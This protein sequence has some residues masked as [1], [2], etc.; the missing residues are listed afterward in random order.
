MKR[1][2]SSLAFEAS[3]PSSPAVKP[4]AVPDSRMEQ[5]DEIQDSPECDPV[6]RSLKE[7][8]ESQF[9]GLSAESVDKITNVEKG[10]SQESSLSERISEPGDK[11][12]DASCDMDTGVDRCLQ[13]DQGQGPGEH[14]DVA[15]DSDCD[16]TDDDQ[17]PKWRRKRI[18]FISSGL[19]PEK[20]VCIY[21]VDFFYK[22]FWP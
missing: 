14:L 22:L 20:S 18:G 8:P 1:V 9:S 19:D 17:L 21:F 2:R 6:P 11:D 16:E 5:F 15:Q 4:S 3:A 7:V 13:N 10:N 12:R